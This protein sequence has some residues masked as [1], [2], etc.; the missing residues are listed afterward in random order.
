MKLC[1]YMKPLQANRFVKLFIFRSPPSLLE[2][3]SYIF[4]FHGLMCGPFCFYKD[5]IAFIEGTN[6]RSAK[7]NHSSVSGIISMACIGQHC[8]YILA[9][10][11]TIFE[12]FIPFSAYLFFERPCSTILAYCFFHVLIPGLDSFTL[13]FSSYLFWHTKQWITDF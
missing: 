5:Y 8:K 13:L 4:C 3:A 12:I 9:L 1:L 11:Y 6:Y 7:P 10:I 2:S